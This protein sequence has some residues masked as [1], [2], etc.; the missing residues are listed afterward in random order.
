MTFANRVEGTV[1]SVAGSGLGAVTLSPTVASLRRAF[2]NL[3]GVG[4][5]FDYSLE[6]GSNFEDGT[7]TITGALT[8]SRVPTCS[9]APSNALVAF[10]AGAKFVHQVND[11]TFASFV[12]KTEGV[13]LDTYL[14]ANLG[15]TIADTDIIAALQ[16]TDLELK[17][18][19]AAQVAAYINTKWSDGT[20]KTVD[21][22]ST[23]AFPLDRSTH[24]RRTLF[25]TVGGTV[26][27]P[28][29]FG[30]V[31]NGFVCELWNISSDTVTVGSGIICLPS[32]ST[33]AAGQR[34][35]VKSRGGFIYAA[36]PSVAVASGGTVPGAATSNA[37]TN[38]T[39]SSFR[40]TWVAP[41]TGDTPIAYTVQR[42]IVG[43]GTWDTVATG[44]AALLFDH[45]GLVAST[46]YETRILATNA[47]GP[48]ATYSNT[49]TGSTSAG[50]V[51]PPGQV[52]G[53]AHGTMTSTTAPLSWSAP[54]TGGAPTAY[55]AE[56]RVTSMGGSWTVASSAVT[57][58]SYTVTGLTASTGY[59]F[60]VTATNAGGSG[61]P[62]A[63]VT[64]T[65]TAAA[66]STITPTVRANAMPVNHK[67]YSGMGF[68][69]HD[70]TITGGPTITAV[71]WALTESDTVYPSG[72]INGTTTPKGRKSTAS[73]YPANNTTGVYILDNFQVDASLPTSTP[74]YFWMKITDSAGGV[75]YFRR[76]AA[77]NLLDNRATL[78]F[79]GTASAHPKVA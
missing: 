18:V 14:E 69:W 55:T 28:G 49:A 72:T 62:S 24:N 42:R 17:G 53:L 11:T 73:L 15:S 7:A 71:E 23:A 39:S 48:S 27:G 68:G 59:D 25:F 77:V 43:A 65:T 29:A 5:T 50:T 56:Y 47:A 35:T 45:T 41:T 36:M 10:T 6:Q 34:A 1:A 57:G 76:T 19:T 26:T 51:S 46:S 22:T 64:G 12:R 74:F 33:L 60:R 58:T 32:G 67:P 16:G 63:V 3:G 40:S 54:S 21:I 70:I 8:F 31:G 30:S 9:S 38:A 20:E 75:Q 52:T 78:T 79:D 37:I 13:A 66:T 4:A 2:S 61:T 44:V